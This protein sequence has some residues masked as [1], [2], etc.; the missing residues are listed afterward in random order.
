MTIVAELWSTWP[1]ITKLR[2][3]NGFADDRC[4]KVVMTIKVTTNNKSDAIA[5]YN[6]VLGLMS[7]SDE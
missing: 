3:S 5:K 1:I 2:F 4:A 7:G 6:I